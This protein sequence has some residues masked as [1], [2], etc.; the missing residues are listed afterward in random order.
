MSFAAST[1]S[2]DY[3]LILRNAELGVYF[4]VVRHS[5]IYG[6][7]LQMLRSNIRTKASVTSCTHLSRLLVRGHLGRPVA[8]V[9]VFLCR[10]RVAHVVR[11]NLCGVLLVPVARMVSGIQ[12]AVGRRVWVR[13]CYR[14][15]LLASPQQESNGADQCKTAHYAANN[16]T[17]GSA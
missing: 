17:D 12:R 9:C 8:S 4:V 3:C 15:V 10:W 1:F 7:L 16:A 14:R 13:L 2:Y 11:G 5:S 6:Y